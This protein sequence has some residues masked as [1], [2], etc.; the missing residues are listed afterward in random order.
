MHRHQ[1]WCGLTEVFAS[2]IEFDRTTGMST[3]NPWTEVWTPAIADTP[4]IVRGRDAVMQ[5]VRNATE[6]VRTVHHGF[7][8]EIEILSERSA[9]GVW[10]MRDEL[11]DKAGR[12]IVSGSGHYHETYELSATGWVIKTARLTRLWLT[13]GDGRRED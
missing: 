13:Y 6:H 9:R 11:Y 7:M 4:I 3:Q 8:P 5:M 12:L 10:A 2:D 1:D